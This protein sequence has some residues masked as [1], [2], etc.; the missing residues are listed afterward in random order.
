[1]SAILICLAIIMLFVGHYYKVQRWNQSISVYEKSNES[2]LLKAISVGQLINLFV[3]FRIGD[4]FRVY[5]SGK[6]MKNGYKLAFATTIL[7][8]YMDTIVV[9]L[10]V[11]TL[12]FI[13]SLTMNSIV[14]FYVVFLISL[15]ILTAFAIKF[16]DNLK[17][18]IYGISCFFNDNIKLNLM[19]LF[20]AIISIFK[21]I[22]FNVN[23]KKLIINTF[24]MW[25]FYFASYYLLAIYLKKTFVDVFLMLYNILSSKIEMIMQPVIV[26]YMSV[27]LLMIY[28]LGLLRK[29]RKMNDDGIFMLP[30]LKN[31]DKMIFLQSYFLNEN[32]TKLKRYLDI[33]RNTFVVD[34]YTSGS[35][36]FTLLCLDNNKY[37]Y[38][39]YALYKDGEKLKEQYEWLIRHKDTVKT[40]RIIGCQHDDDYFSYEMEYNE[41]AIG[42]FKKIHSSDIETSIRIIETVFDDLESSLYVAYNRKNSKIIIEEYIE[43]KVFDNIERIVKSNSSLKDLVRYNKIFINDIEY[44]NLPELMKYLTKE[45]LYDIFKNDNYSDIHG[46]LTI[47]NIICIDD[48]YYLIDPNTGNV[49]ESK[50]LDYSKFLQSIHGNYEFFMKTPY[51]YLKR[52]HIDYFDSSTN[53][54]SEIFKWYKN[55]LETKFSYEECRSIFYHEII[56]WLRLI[57]YKMAKDGDRS[58]LFYA[59]MIKVFNDVVNWYEK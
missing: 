32:S 58:A 6:N 41:S 36:A 30:Q 50:F 48:D 20:W 8:L 40:T 21:D 25:L 51:V 3:P 54:Y 52:D 34:D 33:N 45:H 13:R 28:F 43:K 27:P 18:I 16:K 44:M 31:H 26:I 19:Y 24:L 2:N 23:K 5:I 22:V 49:H 56:H 29:E 10:I 7:D 57:P 15:I 38:K 37:Y 47:E 17:R 1:M 46:D 53:T 59:G 39:K 14:I 4:I 9:S 42:L 12:F 35:N 11:I 55:Y